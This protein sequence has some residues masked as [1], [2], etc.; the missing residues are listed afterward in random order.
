MA[1]IFTDQGLKMMPGQML[2]TQFKDSTLTEVLGEEFSCSSCKEPQNISPSTQRSL[3]RI[4]KAI[5]G[6]KSSLHLIY[7]YI[8]PRAP[9]AWLL[10]TAF[11]EITHVSIGAPFKLA[12]SLLTCYSFRG[13]PP[14]PWTQEDNLI[15]I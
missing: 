14:Q 8:F 5:I 12:L 4:Q 11:K 2:R 10:S 6:S 15:L 13:A 3:Y 1:F 9:T 7:C